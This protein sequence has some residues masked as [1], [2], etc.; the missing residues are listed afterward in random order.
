MLS[1][2][3][4]DFLLDLSKNNNR[5]WFQENKARYERDVKKP[6]ADFTQDVLAG[7]S[8][9]S[10]EGAFKHKVYR[11]NRDVRFSTDKS[12]YKKHVAAVFFP[13]QGHPEVSP[14]YYVHLE[15]GQ[16]MIGGGAYFLE[17]ENLEKVRKHIIYNSETFQEIINEGN[18]VTHFEQIK[19]EK[20]KRLASEFVEAAKIQPLLFNKQFYFMAELNPQLALEADFVPL[21]LRYCNAARRLN[22]FLMEAIG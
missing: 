18:F 4:L 12:P 1:Q 5:D 20:N 22:I 2:T 9:Y 14:G 21:V 6:W 13:T 11:I 10:S 19:G 15:A 17:K 8:P 3:L 7:L 16:L